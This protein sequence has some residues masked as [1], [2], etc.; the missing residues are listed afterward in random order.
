MSTG[1]VSVIIS[2]LKFRSAPFF[3]SSDTTLALTKDSS[4]ISV[5]ECC[6]CVSSGTTLS[7]IQEMSSVVL[8]LLHVFAGVQVK[9]M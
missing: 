2:I 6:D 9:N 3:F 1:I 7:L 8:Q 5:N 4:Y